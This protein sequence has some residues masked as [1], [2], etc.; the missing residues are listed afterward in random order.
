[1]LTKRHNRQTQ[2]VPAPAVIP[3]PI[4]ERFRLMEGLLL[5][6]RHEQDILVR[7]LV[8]TQAQLDAL[9]GLS[10]STAHLNGLFKL[11]QRQ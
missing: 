5:E 11:R 10:P 7:R 3:Q 6:M 2:D 9:I 4:L 8:T 1:M